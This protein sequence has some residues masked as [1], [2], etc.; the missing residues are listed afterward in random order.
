M[1]GSSPLARGLLQP[2][3]TPGPGRSD[4]PRSRG[5]YVFVKYCGAGHT[6][7]SPLARGLQVQLGSASWW[8]R[9]I[10]ARAGFTPPSRLRLRRSGDH[11][12][13]RGVY[14]MG[15]TNFMIASGSSPLARGLPLRGVTATE[16]RRIIP[17]RAGFTH[18][19]EDTYHGSPDHPRSRGV[20]VDISFGPDSLAG[21]SPLARGLLDATTGYQSLPT[22]HPRSRGVY[23]FGVTL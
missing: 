19:E 20:Y 15:F 13:S 23:G 14:F 22:D 18:L 12:R 2:A 16:A 4:H 17:A 5:V 10:P 3:G 8:A 6:G 7:S 9:I 21:S 11:P 1:G